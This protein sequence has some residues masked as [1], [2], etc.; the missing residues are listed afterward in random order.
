[1]L[2]PDFPTKLKGK[3]VDEIIDQI[4]FIARH[5]CVFLY[6]FIIENHS[7]FLENSPDLLDQFLAWENHPIQILFFLN[8]VLIVQE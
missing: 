5:R 7:L 3:D 2:G 1:M 6:A 4:D 8:D